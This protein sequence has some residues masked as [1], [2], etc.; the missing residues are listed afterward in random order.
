MGIRLDSFH[1]PINKRAGQNYP[2][3]T[4]KFVE[5][6]GGNLR[7]QIAHRKGEEK[8]EQHSLCHHPHNPPK[9]PPKESRQLFRRKGKII[10]KNVEAIRDAKHKTGRDRWK[11]GP[12][13]CTICR[14]KK[15][16]ALIS[17][18]ITFQNIRAIGSLVQYDGGDIRRQGVLIE[19]KKNKDGYKILVS[20]TLWATQS[21]GQAKKIVGGKKGKEHR[22]I[23]QSQN[24]RGRNTPSQPC[25]LPVHEI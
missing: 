13:L 15:G 4:K 17:A 10:R 20:W 1:Q 8:K 14:E 25:Q 6:R 18:P 7:A 24:E 12:H 23:F 11:P 9:N 2:Q 16:S 21:K 19:G 5:R 22:N 3:S